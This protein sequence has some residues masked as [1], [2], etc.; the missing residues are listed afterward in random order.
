MLNPLDP[1]NC[2][3]AQPTDNPL[4]G[5][6]AAI[7]PDDI[8]QALRRAAPGLTLDGRDTID[9]IRSELSCL[10]DLIDQAKSVNEPLGLASLLY[11]YCNAL[12]DVA[13]QEDIAGGAA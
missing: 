4:P 9:R 13:A 2:A 12:D 8:H 7:G 5:T 1:S 3:T 6:A 10:A 11:G